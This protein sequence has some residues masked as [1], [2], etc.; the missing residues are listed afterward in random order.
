MIYCLQ[1]EQIRD[2]N[3]LKLVQMSRTILF[4]RTEI[5]DINV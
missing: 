3:S 4:L 1:C 5:S 2:I